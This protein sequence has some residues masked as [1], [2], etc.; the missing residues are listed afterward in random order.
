MTKLLKYLKNIEFYY[1]FVNI[2]IHFVTF[3]NTP[4]RSISFEKEYIFIPLRKR[5]FKILLLNNT[6]DYT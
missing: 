2:W 5:K 4:K 1:L 6:V 3:E